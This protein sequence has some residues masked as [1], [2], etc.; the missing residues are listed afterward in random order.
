[1]ETKTI[2]RVNNVAIVAGNDASK[3]VPIKPICD[4]LGI[5]FPNQFRKIKEDEDLN[6][7]VVLSTMVA[8]DGKD[9]EMACLPLEFVFGWLFTINPKN[10]KPEAQAAVRTYRME[11]YRALYKHFSAYSKFNEEKQNKLSA[12]FE[13][14]RELKTNFNQ[15]KKEMQE[16]ERRMIEAKNMTFESWEQEQRQQSIDFSQETSI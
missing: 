14:F 16:S 1:M 9:R 10:V 4:A 15:A 2:A 12:E 11:C 7:T 5:D 13:K 3:L 6:S 8:S